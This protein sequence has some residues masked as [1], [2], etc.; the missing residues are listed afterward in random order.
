MTYSQ[1]QK[2]RELVI[3][4]RETKDN[5]ILDELIRLNMGMLNI[6]AKQAWAMNRRCRSIEDE[7][8]EIAMKFIEVVKYYYD[9]DRGYALTTYFCDIYRRKRFN[10]VFNHEKIIKLPRWYSKD[11]KMP[12]VITESSSKSTADEERD[13]IVD[14]Y[15]IGGHNAKKCMASATQEQSDLVLDLHRKEITDKIWE[16]AASILPD[17]DYK[18][19]FSRFAEDK[20][21]QQ[22]ADEYG[23]TRENIRRRLEICLTKLRNELI[24]RNLFMSAFEDEN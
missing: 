15:A 17:R 3:K 23:C 10:F 5:A 12:N 1:Q 16:L 14:F 18:I 19:F 22:I 8:Q 13:H 11:A 6:A 21:Q 9:P 4:Y 20:T 7:F 24:E 2:N